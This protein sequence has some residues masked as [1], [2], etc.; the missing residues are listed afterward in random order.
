MDT[1][2]IMNR[3]LSSKLLLPEKTVENK[4][5]MEPSKND[6]SQIH[7]S[8]QNITPSMKTEGPH[9]REQKIQVKHIRR[10]DIDEKNKKNGINSTMDRHSNQST[11]SQSA[12]LI[13]HRQSPDERSILNTDVT[14]ENESTHNPSSKASRIHRI[15]VNKVPH[16]ELP[17]SKRSSRSHSKSRRSVN[18]VKPM[19]TLNVVESKRCRSNTVTVK[20]IP[21][22]SIVEI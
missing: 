17:R 2:L 9:S 10:I 16:D 20:K 7:L 12:I 15:S 5:Q 11:I 6:L 14:V 1:E 18:Q 3:S 21:R 19:A 4:F 13:D 8:N 22:T